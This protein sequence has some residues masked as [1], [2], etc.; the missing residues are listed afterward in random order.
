MKTLF[1]RLSLF[2]FVLFIATNCKDDS[3]S[4]T[5]PEAGK[6]EMTLDANLWA[7]TEAY[8]VTTASNDTSALIITAV[9]TPKVE[10]SPVS[11]LGIIVLNTVSA[12]L[13]GDYSIILENPHSETETNLTK[14]AYLM[15]TDGTNRMW[16]CTS[17]SFKITKA[18]DKVVQGTFE[19]TLTEISEMVETSNTG[20]SPFSIPKFKLGTRQLNTALTLKDGGFNLAYNLVSDYQ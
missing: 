4:N 16:V 6:L 7:A 13:V 18:K 2:I 11:T 19:G 12:N 1:I 10:S 20:K 5:I 9:N 14:G 17:G 8:A 3:N 15:Y